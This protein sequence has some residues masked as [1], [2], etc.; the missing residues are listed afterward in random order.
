[1]KH[2]NRAQILGHAGGAP[3]RH[4][5][6]DGARTFVTFSVATNLRW[7]DDAGET[8]ESTEWHRVVAGGALADLVE[9]HVARGDP[10]L[11]EGRLTTRT[12]EDTAGMERRTTEIQATDVVFLARRAAS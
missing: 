9:Q 4:Q 2:L 3:E 10:V 12:W 1:M 8:H 6:R 11:V 7:K 5:T